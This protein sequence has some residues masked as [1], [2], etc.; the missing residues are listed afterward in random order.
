MARAELATIDLPDF[1]MPDSRPDL[2]ASLYPAR[3]ARLRGRADARD[4]DALVV[5][6]DREHSAN[7]AW[8]TGFDPRFEKATLVV[9]PTDEPLILV[10]NGGVRRV[11]SG[12]LVAHHGP[13]AVHG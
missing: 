10:G 11:V 2:P 1:G 13:P 8:P 12:R 9:R 4:L 5:C 3:L 6:S 7:L